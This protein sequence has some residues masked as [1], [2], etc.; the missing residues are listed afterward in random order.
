MSASGGL[1]LAVTDKKHFGASLLHAT[2]SAEHVEQLGQLASDKGFELKTDGLYRGRKL[3]ASTTEEDI[4]EALGLQFIEPELREG[5]DELQKAAKTWPA[6]AC[7]RQRPSR[8]P[9]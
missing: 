5:R 6:K 2:G 8:H 9:S 3:I 1:K 4:Y 7:A